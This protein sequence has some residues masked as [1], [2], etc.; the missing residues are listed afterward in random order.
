MPRV[1]HVLSQRPSLTGSGITIDA[2]VRQAAL[3]GWEQAAVVGT[4]ADDPRPA[5][6]ELDTR[7]IHPLIFERPPLD[8]PLPGMSDVMPYRSTRFSGMDEAQLALYRRQWSEHLRTAIAETR[9]DLIHAHHLW[10]VGSMI[11]R[12]APHVPVVSHC[13]ATGLRQMSLCPHLADEVRRG[14]A[15]NDAFLTLHRQDAAAV[16]AA[17]G[18]ERSRIRVSGAGY[19][20]ELFHRRGRTPADGYRLIYVGKFSAAKGLPCL[21]DALRQLEEAG[22]A[23]RLHVV[24]DGSGA[25]ADVL[26]ERMLSMPSVVLHGTMSQSRLADLLRECDMFVLPSF[27]EGLPLVAVE[28]AACGC[29]PLVTD[30]PG[31]RE[32]GD[33]LGALLILIPLPR[34]VGIDTPEPASLPGFVAGIVRA[35]RQAR[36]EQPSYRERAPDLAAFTWHSVF[37]RV[38][39]LW[40]ELLASRAGGGC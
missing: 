24:G 10:I 31:V 33:A 11:K 4:P 29:R 26:R 12:I 17:L 30:L 15:G 19:R 35:I 37:G 40:N 38:E 23:P 22:E 32:L 9:P 3:A 16:A 39:R 1:L 6:G 28:A 18:V 34:M 14:C 8:F 13:H 5:V 27:Y 2:L 21:L 25:E 20:E 36:A 7:S